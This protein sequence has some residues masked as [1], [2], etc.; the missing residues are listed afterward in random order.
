MSNF[1]KKQ[2]KYIILILVVLFTIKFIQSCN[3][4]NQL[5]YVQHKNAKL[6]IQKDSICLIKTNN[7]K[8]SIKILNNNIKNKDKTIEYL[9]YKVRVANVSSAAA[10]KR[11]EAIQKT[12]SAIRKNTTISIQNISKENDSTIN[13]K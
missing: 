5:Y 1:I 4:S 9:K 11:A 2:Y 7:L 8:D 12:V 3:R 10:N 6:L 13:K